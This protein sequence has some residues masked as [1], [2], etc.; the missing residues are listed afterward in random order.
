MLGANAVL[1]VAVPV[2]QTD[3]PLRRSELL[4]TLSQLKQWKVHMSELDWDELADSSVIGAR[5]FE[6]G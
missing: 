5:L 3:V 6:Q 4:S 2:N 1:L